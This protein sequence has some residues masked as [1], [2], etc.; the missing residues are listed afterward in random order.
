MG[1]LK[2]LLFWS[3]DVGFYAGAFP[4]SLADG[5]DGPADGYE[6]PKMLT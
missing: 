4:V 3:L 2:G 1:D 5:I 6:N